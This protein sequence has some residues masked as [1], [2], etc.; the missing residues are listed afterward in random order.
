MPVFLDVHRIPNLEMEKKIEDRVDS[1]K[2]EFG[3]THI[4]I[5]FKRSRSVLL[6]VRCSKQGSNRETSF[7]G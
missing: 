3:V 4:N 2:N 1:P 5:F 7:K 6:F